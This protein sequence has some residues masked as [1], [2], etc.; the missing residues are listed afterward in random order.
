M[1]NMNDSI[2]TNMGL[3]PI[4]D[5]LDIRAWEYGYDSYQEMREDGFYIPV[6]A[7]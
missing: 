1:K 4:D 2:E 3:M 7:E 5:Y 6:F